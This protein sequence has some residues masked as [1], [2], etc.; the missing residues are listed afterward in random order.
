MVSNL[1]EAC[2]LEMIAAWVMRSYDTES[3][4]PTDCD[5]INMGIIVGDSDDF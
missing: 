4:L 3:R 5:V 1:K 2:W